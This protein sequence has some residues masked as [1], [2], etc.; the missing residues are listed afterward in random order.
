MEHSGVAVWG[1]TVWEVVGGRRFG[2]MVGDCCGEGIR[3]IEGDG[4]NG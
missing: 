4:E 3:G 2:E 1:Q